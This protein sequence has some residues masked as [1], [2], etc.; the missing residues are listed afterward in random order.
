[1]LQ[2]S[3][4]S[5]ALTSE[6]ELLF[7]RSTDLLEE[8]RQ[9]EG[10][11]SAGR[12]LV[13]GRLKVSLPTVLARRVIVPR[14]GEFM[15]AYPEVQ[16]DITLDDRVIDVIGGGYDLALRTGDLLDSGLVGKRIGRHCFVVCGSP[17]YFA[18]HAKPL[19]PDDI[20]GHLCLRFRYPSSGQLETW[21]F[22][23][24][25]AKKSFGRTLIFNDSDAVLAAALAG[26]GVAQLPDYAT[27]AAEAQG[28]LQVVLAEH[29]QDRGGLWIVWPPSRRELPRIK[30]FSEFLANAV[31]P[32]G[33]RQLPD[34]WEADANALIEI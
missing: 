7:A 17:A 5:I 15:A 20:D 3:T 13:K 9:T 18:T 25:P 6:G 12:A 1:L 29:A 21:A 16:L 28:L 31:A 14:L 22:K 10:A 34:A 32:L 33:Q 26:I 2:R 30:V 8:L 11:V 24:R 4:R 23:G 19:D 27:S